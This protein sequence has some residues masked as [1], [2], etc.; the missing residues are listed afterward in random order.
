MQVGPGPLSSPSLPLSLTP[1]PPLS[2][3]LPLHVGF[4]CHATLPSTGRVLYPHDSI[5]EGHLD[6]SQY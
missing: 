5:Q 4:H 6:P 1:A 2:L 3:P